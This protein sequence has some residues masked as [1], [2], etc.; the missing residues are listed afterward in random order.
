MNIS[1]NQDTRFGPGRFYSVFLLFFLWILFGFFFTS[2]IRSQTHFTIPN[3]VWRL[4]VT[5]KILSGKYI[6]P[7]GVKGIP[8]MPFSLAGYGKRYYDHR[9]LLDGY[10]ASSQDLYD[11]DTL[12]FNSTY[13]VGEYIRHYNLMFGDSIPDFSQDFFG[14]DSIAITGSISQEIS[15]NSW[16]VDFNVEYGLSNRITFSMK[17]PY[18][19]YVAEDRTSRWNSDNIPGLDSWVAYHQGVKAA[20]DSALAHHYDINLQ[21]IRNQFYSWEGD[22]STLWALG[23]DP[24]NH[25]FYGSEFNPF[26]QQ[27]TSSVTIDELLSYY[28]PE[29]RTTSG[30]GDVELGLNILL[31]GNP[32]WSE[33]GNFS[34]YTGLF[35]VMPSA[36]RLEKYKMSNGIPVNQ[37][38]FLQLPLGEG[39]S[40]LNFSLFGELYQTLFRR[41][42]IINWMVKG[43]FHGQKR[44]NTPIRFVYFNTFNPDTIAT[45]LG[46]DFTFRKGNEFYGNI[47]GQLE[48]IP[49]RISISGGSSVYLKGR[50]T[51]ISKNKDWDRWM[52]YRKG[53]YDTRRSAVIQH[54]EVT[55]HNVNPLKRIGPIPF[56]LVG[57]VSIPVLSRNTYR[58]FS[59]WLQWI[60]Y[61]QAW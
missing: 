34:I 49:D 24:Y 30:L 22:H 13:N 19:T 38:H 42:I 1:Q 60:V 56:E 21:V 14:P 46:Q 28:Y 20:M 39:V 61:A 51:Y 35:F 47:L 31:F 33:S 17:I 18:Y 45:L 57:G 16:G 2:S 8:N 5:P 59:A 36:Y 11:L 50:D 41:Q 4:S 25:R 37:A 15:R 32:A 6:G 26:T 7:G 40:Q 43:G 54:A 58:D 29:R 53:E 55:L 23:G 44:L 27:D 10:P 48:L 3:N 52:E 9:F 12:G